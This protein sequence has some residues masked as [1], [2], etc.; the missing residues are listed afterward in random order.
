MEKKTLLIIDL[1]GGIIAAISVFLA[2]ITASAGGFSVS[3]SGW[4]LLRASISDVP[5][6]AVGS[7]EIAKA[8]N[9]KLK[10]MRLEAG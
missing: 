8:I 10:S 3:M 2:W 9:D 4:D 5:Y 7:V 1:V 6:V